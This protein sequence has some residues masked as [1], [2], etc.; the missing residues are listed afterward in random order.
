MGK[1]R[2][3]EVHLY[4]V[5]SLGG[6]FVGAYRPIQHAINQYRP[7]EFVN[8]NFSNLSVLDYGA[9][10]GRLLGLIG[11]MGV[12]RSVGVDNSHPMLTAAKAISPSI[13]VAQMGERLPFSSEQFDLVLSTV[14]LVDIPSLDKMAH[15]LEEA[16]RVLKPT[17][18]M[19]VVTATPESYRVDTESFK[20]NFSENIGLK[21]GD[22][23]KV[24][25]GESDEAQYDYVW[26]DTDHQG[27]IS[28]TNLV[29]HETRQVFEAGIPLWQVYVIGRSELDWQSERVALFASAREA[30]K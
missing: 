7:D 13:Q 27:V 19:I 12:K 24:V 11:M 20:C 3:S 28:A 30:T 16:Q 22:Q 18:T 9:G 5:E 26:T 1:Y 6:S 10:V 8:R 23:A 25:I 29:L 17:G 15:Y 21:S 4:N 2:D 14:V